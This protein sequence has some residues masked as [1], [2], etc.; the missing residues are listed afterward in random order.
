MLN[1]KCMLN[2]KSPDVPGAVYIE[3]DGAI[4]RSDF[5]SQGYESRSRARGA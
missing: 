5:E 4:V 3:G 2:A 1:A